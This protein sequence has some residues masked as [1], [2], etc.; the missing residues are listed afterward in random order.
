MAPAKK[1]A[2][3]KKAPAKKKAPRKRRTENKIKF[4]II[5]QP[6]TGS[7]LLHTCLRQHSDIQI[8]GELLHQVPGER[9]ERHFINAN[10]KYYD[11]RDASA[12]QFLDEYLWSSS[13]TK[14]CVGFKYFPYYSV[15]HSREKLFHKFSQENVKMVHIKRRNKLDLWASFEA[16]SQKKQFAIFNGHEESNI[17]LE[18]IYV[19]PQKMHEHFNSSCKID[20]KI[21]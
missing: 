10:G 19:T 8:E 9:E 7:T 16:A 18:K 11:P 20:N 4:V 6:R 2:V 21:S 1:K 17:K 3:A 12:D 15:E 13:S 5:G 14:S